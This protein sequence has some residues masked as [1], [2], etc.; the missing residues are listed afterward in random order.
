MEDKITELRKLRDVQGTDGNWN[1][2]P[3]LHGM[4]NGTEF[5]LA[6]MEGRDPV[7]KEAPSEWLSDRPFARS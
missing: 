5:S 6:L 1:Y 2:D 3:Y 7:Y 4:Y